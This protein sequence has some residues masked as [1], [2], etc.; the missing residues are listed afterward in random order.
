MTTIPSRPP[1]KDESPEEAAAQTARAALRRAQKLNSILDVA[2]A[3]T[4]ERDLDALLEL[5]LRETKR[6]VE[7]D[8]CTIF[9]LD[10]EHDVLWSRV[11]QGLETKEIRLPVGQ[12]IAGWVAQNNAVLNI[13]DAYADERFHRSVDHATGYRTR[14]V[15]CAPMRGA[16]GELV[17]CIQALNRAGDSPFDEEDEELL[18]ALGG[19]AAAAIQNTL[20]HQSVE[21]LFEGFVKASVV[22]I[23]SRDPT[24]SGHS[25]R[26][27]ALTVALAKVVDEVDS[28]LYR[29]ATFG[30]RDI[31]ELR[32]AALLHDFGKVGVR[33]QVLVK[34]K[35]L[36]PH[37]L[38]ALRMR[39]E[40]VKTT[41]ERDHVRSVLDRAPK[42]EWLGTDQAERELA[43]KLAE[44][45]EMWDFI[46]ACNRPT[47]LEEGSFERLQDL[48]RMEVP[49][50]S[51]KTF[52]L[53][54][55]EVTVL[56]I[57]KGSLSAEERAEIES[58]VTHTFRFLSQIPW[59]PE[60]RRVP[61]VAYAHHEKLDGGGY[62]RG[63]P[64]EQ[65]P[66]GARMMAIADI[67]D[68]LAARDR[69]YKKA[70]PHE[71]ALDILRS[72]AERGFL[73]RELLR[74]FIDKDVVG[75]ALPE[76]IR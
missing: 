13:P 51:G 50:G 30:Q 56:S 61:Q 35:K 37:E 74:L 75:Q 60:L 39:F 21:K 58:H 54:P 1:E 69:P 18:L 65:I 46:E 20:L 49:M 16:G 71:K 31:R 38:E 68:A 76:S 3:M 66:L 6:V 23:E 48:A 2:K 26:V 27:A 17:G 10:S 12:G 41:I 7:A 36:Y 8:R 32:Y 19:Q 57:P 43:E 72:E 73:D 9:I 47:I 40:L 15:L 59:T 42:N 63:L 25:E 55:D 67:Y 64:E 34:S 33:E 52:L 29:D 28:G 22:A 4:V 70:V 5:I 45:D 11:A 44:L 53:S 14:N 24:T 62:P